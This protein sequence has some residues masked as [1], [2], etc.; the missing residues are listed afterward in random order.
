MSVIFEV[1]N[2]RGLKKVRWAP[3]GVCALVGPNGSGKTTLLRLGGL[4][5]FTT[6]N[7]LHEGLAVSGGVWGLKYADALENDT[8]LLRV[9]HGSAGLPHYISL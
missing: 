4:L 8:V 5:R 2:Y 7:S 1:E 6:E 9:T 3:S